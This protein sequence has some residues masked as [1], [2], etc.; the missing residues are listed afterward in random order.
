MGSASL[1]LQSKWS[2]GGCTWADGEKLLPVFF[3]NSMNEE[4]VWQIRAVELCQNACFGLNISSEPR[5]GQGPGTRVRVAEHT[6]FSLFL[7]ITVVSVPCFADFHGVCVL[8]P[9]TS[10]RT[11]L[12]TNFVPVSESTTISFRRE[13]VWCFQQRCLCPNSLAAA[14]SKL[15]LGLRACGCGAGGTAALLGEADLHMQSHGDR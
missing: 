10:W 15:L 8:D 7:Y 2:E 6:T 1:R 4:P 12:L 14:T 9:F 3:Y 5:G 11:V 13:T